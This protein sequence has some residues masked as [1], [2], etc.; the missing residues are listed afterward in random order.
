M[1]AQMRKLQL[2]LAVVIVFSMILTACAA[3]ATPAP[4]AKAA[5]TTAPA[6]A[7]PAATKAPRTHQ[8]A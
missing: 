2:L 6:A 7:R 3:P 5:P 8:G 4:A 1:S